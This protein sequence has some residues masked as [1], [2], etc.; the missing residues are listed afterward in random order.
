M[1]PTPSFLSSMYGLTVYVVK[2]MYF[3]I[4]EVGSSVSV[5]LNEFMVINYLD[6]DTI[7][8]IGRYISTQGK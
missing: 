3:K 1:I 2:Y 7:I 6:G 5:Q 4:N 8:R